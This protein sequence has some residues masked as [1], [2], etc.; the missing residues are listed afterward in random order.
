M[1]L[2][3]ALALYLAIGLVAGAAFV[4]AGVVQFAHAPVT[5]GA[6]I[7]LLPGATLLWPYIVHQWFKSRRA[8]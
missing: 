5:L 6:R 8:P 4:I 3:Y 1:I 7:L 2:L